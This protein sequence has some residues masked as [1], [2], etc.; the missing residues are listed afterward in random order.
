[1]RIRRAIKR[2]RI[3]LVAAPFEAIRRRYSAPDQLARKGSV[4]DTCPRGFDGSVVGT[5]ADAL[6]S[7]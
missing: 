5:V 4:A 1:V 2:L 6:Y 7:R 3:L